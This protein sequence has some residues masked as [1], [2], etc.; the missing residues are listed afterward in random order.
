MLLEPTG[1]ELEQASA[2]RYTI[3]EGDSLS[4]SAEHEM[5]VGLRRG[6]A[7]D[8]RCVRGRLDDGNRHAFPGRTDA[9]G[10]RGGQPDLAASLDVRGAA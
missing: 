3:V 8:T 1:T 6:E 7:W 9:P 5:V 4:A 2:N 10:V